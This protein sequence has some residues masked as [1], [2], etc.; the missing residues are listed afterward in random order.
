MTI[1]LGFKSEA[2]VKD[3]KAVAI[4]KED[5]RLV[6]EAIHRILSTSPRERLHNPQFGC[7]IQEAIFE[8]LRSANLALASFFIAD[9]IEKFEPR[10]KIK[11]ITPTILSDSRFK[12][13]VVFTMTN[14]PNTLLRTT[15][16]I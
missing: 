16:I 11:L 15:R 1:G 13:D 5:E 8:E 9:A 7:R 6:A 3:L 4:V 14:N 12:I 10:V 2:T